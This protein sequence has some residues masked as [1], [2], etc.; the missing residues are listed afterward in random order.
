MAL[1]RSSSM[2]DAHASSIGSPR[3]SRDRQRSLS[4]NSSLSSIDMD[5]LDQVDTEDLEHYHPDLGRVTEVEVD[6][7]EECDDEGWREK[8]NAKAK[9]AL[10]KDEEV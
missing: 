10:A 3:A 1:T 6:E 2:S 9:A 8:P 5:S 4:S 7:A